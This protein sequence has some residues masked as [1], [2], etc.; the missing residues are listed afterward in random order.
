MASA[1]RCGGAREAVAEGKASRHSRLL[2]EACR[3]GREPPSIVARALVSTSCRQRYIDVD[4]DADDQ[5]GPRR[6]DHERN[7]R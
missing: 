6:A 5:A 1:A 4:P 2:M 3:L 7:L